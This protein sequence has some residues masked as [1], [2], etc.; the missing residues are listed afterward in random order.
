MLADICRTGGTAVYELVEIGYVLASLR[1]FA[2]VVHLGIMRGDER[3]QD[4]MGSSV[5]LEQRVPQHHPLREIRNLTD[6][7]LRSLSDEFDALYS[8]SAVHR[9][10]P[11]MCCEHCC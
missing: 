8:A 11:S 2:Q 6:V 7:F 9:S 5:T 3:V 4:E 1:L 10:Y